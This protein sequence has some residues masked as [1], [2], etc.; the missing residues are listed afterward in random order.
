MK[1]ATGKLLSLV[2][3]GAMLTAMAAPAL[4][5]EQTDHDYTAGIVEDTRTVGVTLSKA[6]AATTSSAFIDANHTY[7]AV[8]LL[9]LYKVLEADHETQA[10]DAEGKLI[11]QYRLADGMDAMSPDLEH[12]LSEA[13]FKFDYSADGFYTG[14]ITMADDSEIASHFGEN[15]RTSDASALAALIAQA[16]VKDGISGTEMKLDRTVELESGYWIIYE[17]DN[18]SP[19]KKDGTVATKPILVDVRKMLGTGTQNP[20]I[21]LTLKDAKVEMEKVITNDDKFSS[22]QDN[23]A[24]GDIV[25]YKITTNFPVYEANAESTFREASFEIRDTLEDAL[26]LKADSFV[27]KVNG[28]AYEETRDEGSLVIVNFR[29]TTAAHTFTIRFNTDF[30]LAHQGEDIEVTYNA[31]LNKTAEFNDADGNRN[32]AWVEYSNNPEVKNQTL[33]LQD[34]TSVYTYAIDLRKLDGAYDTHLAGVKFNMLKEDGSKMKFVVEGTNYIYDSTGEAQ[35]ATDEIVTVDEDLHFIGLD[36]GSYTLHEVE[37]VTGYS[38][39]ANDAVITIAGNKVTVGEGAAAH[40]ELDGAAN[41]KTVYAGLVRDEETYDDEDAEADTTHEEDGVSDVNV[42]VRNY[43]GI[44]LP[45]TGSI[46]AITLSGLGAA[47]AAAGAAYMV[48]KKKKDEE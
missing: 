1:K 12:L 21:D 20:G 2:M 33:T 13:G 11:F 41:V 17:S 46:T 6:D 3:A 7:T 36:E 8:K 15:E 30:I 38:L 47:V 37:T 31:Q 29:N 14:A 23:R 34:E 45:E 27:V 19:E 43:K 28:T 9:D 4:A 24:V 48:A 25:S 18:S 42:I 16:V 35:G 40:E 44:Y 26:D 39:L 10:R 5:A 32:D 22:K